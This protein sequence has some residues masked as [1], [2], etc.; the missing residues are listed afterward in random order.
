[1]ESVRS[2]CKTRWNVEWVYTSSRC[3]YTFLQV[4]QNHW[5]AVQQSIHQRTAVVDACMSVVLS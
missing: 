2:C 5:L 4:M 3:V 1:M